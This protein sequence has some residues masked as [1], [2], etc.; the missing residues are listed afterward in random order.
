MAT[1]SQRHAIFNTNTHIR[2]N[3]LISVLLSIQ[4][5]YLMYFKKTDMKDEILEY[6]ENINSLYFCNSIEKNKGCR[7]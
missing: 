6:Y 3:Q 5:N 4:H 1:E 2:H 7:F